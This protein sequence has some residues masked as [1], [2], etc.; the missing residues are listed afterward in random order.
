M[1]LLACGVMLILILISPDPTYAQSDEQDIRTLVAAQSQA[2]IDL[3]SQIWQWAELGYQESQ[4]SAALQNY[5]RDAGFEISPGVADIPTAFVASFGRG[6]PSIG[7]LAEFDALPGLSQSAV[8]HR[9]T[10]I[11]DAP[12]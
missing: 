12:G 11:E 9:Q 3:A 7:I 4:S 8:P 6:G 1:K 5:L 2:S 10:R